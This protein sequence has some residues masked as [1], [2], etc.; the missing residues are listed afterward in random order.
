M[1]DSPF[2]IVGYGGHAK[3]I[4]D[5]L[6]RTN[7]EIHY[8]FDCDPHK[9]G[10]M[11][12][13]GVKIQ[14]IPDQAWWESH[15]TQAIMA[16]G[17]NS[18]RKKIATQ[19]GNINWGQC[20]HPSS[21][22]HE[23][24]HIGKGVYIGANVLI[25]PG[26]VIGDH[27]IINSGAIIEH[28]VTLHD[29]CHIAPGSILTGG[30]SVGE[31]TLIGAGSILIPNRSVGEWSIIGAGSVIVKDIASHQKAVGNPCKII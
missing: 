17:N 5:G 28:D 4:I 6:K 19:L 14:K 9:I 12:D 23:G 16:I 21:L 10:E 24:T 8:I 3:I 25:Q 30:V 11:S 31:G 22:I 7:K 2:V 13:I 15:S 26:V 27:V 1:V 18:D 20:I 29:Y